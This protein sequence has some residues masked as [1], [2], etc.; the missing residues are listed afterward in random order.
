MSTLNTNLSGKTAIVTGAASGIGREIARVYAQA[1]AAVGIAD[2]NLEG[3]QAVARE[4]AEQGGR[5]L[6]VAM[7]V[8]D[9]DAVNA[10]IDQVAEAFGS[11]DILVSNAGIQ[12]VNPI[13]SYAYSD[14]KKMQA[15]HV[16]GAFLTTKAALKYMYAGDRGGVVI[17]MGSV[18]SHE[19]SPL[20]SAYVAAKHALLGLARVL[21]KEGAAHHVRSHVI[22]PGFV[23]TPLVDK[24]IPEQAKELGISEE[25][26]VKRVML[27]ATVDGE[28]TT[29]D[30]VAQLALFLAAYP[31]AA[32]TGQ[33][34]LVSHG[35]SMK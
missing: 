27:G 20:K 23:R 9:E 26:V 18:H 29:A 21:A 4:I 34:F 25:E 14:W 3:A 13:E 31:S 17:Y 33:S 12:I 28:F 6:G 1:G 24:Q 5:A 10:G 30:D 16:D 19:A 15:I 32:L 2:L 35:W 8:T 22:C 11:M 7:D